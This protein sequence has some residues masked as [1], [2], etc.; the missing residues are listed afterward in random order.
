MKRT[1]FLILFLSF[2]AGGGLAAQSF[3]LVTGREPVTSLDGLWRF[4]TGDNPAWASPNFDDSQWPLLRSDEDWGKQGYLGLKGLAWYR[5]KVVIPGD[6]GPLSLLLPPILTNYEVYADG[7]LAGGC[8]AMPPHPEGRFCTPGIY[9]LPAETYSGSQTVTIALRVWQQTSW[10]SYEGGGPYGTSYLGS[11]P[12]LRA[13]F[14][15][16]FDTHILSAMQD[17]ILVLLE[18]LGGLVSLALFL[19]RRREREYLWFGCTVL[20]EAAASACNI[21][22]TLHGMEI[23]A[24]YGYHNVLVALSEFTTVAFYFRLLR[25]REVL[26]RLG[27]PGLG[28]DGLGGR[29]ER[30]R[31]LSGE[32]PPA[33]RAHGVVQPRRHERLRGRCGDLVARLHRTPQ[34]ERNDRLVLHHAAQRLGIHDV[35]SQRRRREQGQDHDR[36]SLH[37]DHKG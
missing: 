4:H 1:A 31:Q 27:H 34:R 20:L 16:G 7:V 35:G 12:L 14:E 5:F 3:S 10:S 22:K 25:G 33:A 32:R 26:L 2:S 13:R 18:T 6:S 28:Q 11:T 29:V 36:R 8:G 17:Y 15:S 9:A 23:R 37:P 24:F 21:H 30:W 19:F